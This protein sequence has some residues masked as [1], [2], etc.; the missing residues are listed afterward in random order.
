MKIL[1][2]LIINF[3]LVENFSCSRLLVSREKSIK[4]IEK[5]ALEFVQYAL[6]KFKHEQEYGADDL[7]A[8][9]FYINQ[10]KELEKQYKTPNV[11]WYSRQG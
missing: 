2:I 5:K 7:H 8:L 10:M 11:Y 3:I 4:S 6:D 1:I 9:L